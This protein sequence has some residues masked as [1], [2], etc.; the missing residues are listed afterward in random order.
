MTT[1]NFGKYAGMDI[2]DVPLEYLEWLLER[3]VKSS[4]D[5]TGE[6]ERRERLES[7]DLPLIE[8]LIQTGYRSLAKQMHP[9]AGGSTAQ[10]QELNNVVEALRHAV[11]RK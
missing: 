1:L 6:I 11:R 4:Q 9:D 10:M 2:R 3:T 7:A 5:I 8:R